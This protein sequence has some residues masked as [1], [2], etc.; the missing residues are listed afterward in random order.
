MSALDDLL[1]S[2]FESAF[3]A[4]GMMRGSTAPLKRSIVGMAVGAGA[5]YALKPA[6]SFLPSGAPRPWV[7]LKPN[8]PNATMVPWWMPGIAT[9]FV[10]GV[11]I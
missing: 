5:T 10:F 2:P 9:G 3:D 4:V 1:I 7:A 6:V 11:L 8:D